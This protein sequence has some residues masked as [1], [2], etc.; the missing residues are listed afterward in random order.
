MASMAGLARTLSL[1]FVTQI[2]GAQTMLAEL[3][4]LPGPRSMKTIQRPKLSS[5]SSA[6]MGGPHLN[7]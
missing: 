5:V 1:P 2:V 4:E 3:W 7:L 6:I